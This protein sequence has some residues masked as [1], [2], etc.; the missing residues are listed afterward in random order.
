MFDLKKCPIFANRYGKVQEWLNWPA[1]K[2]SKRQKRFR[3]SNPLLSAKYKRSKGMSKD[4]FLFFIT[5]PQ[6]LFERGGDGKQRKLIYQHL[7]SFTFC[8]EPVGETGD[9]RKRSR[10]SLRSSQSHIENNHLSA[11]FYRLCMNTNV[12]IRAKILLETLLY[13][14][15]NLVCFVKRHI[16]IHT[17]M[18]L[19]SVIASNTASAQMVW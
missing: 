5:S 9:G 11:L 15:C 10:H 14:C 1:W 16:A 18:H 17:D 13:G 8:K 12:R 19:Y 2:A 6:T 7:A 4:I 3:G